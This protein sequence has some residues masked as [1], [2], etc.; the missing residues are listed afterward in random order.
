MKL[1][2]YPLD[3]LVHYPFSHY[4]KTIFTSPPSV[5]ATFLVASKASSVLLSERKGN[6]AHFHPNIAHFNGAPTPD[7]LDPNSEESTKF[8]VEGNYYRDV[9]KKFGLGRGGFGTLIFETPR[10]YDNMHGL[11]GADGTLGQ[12]LAVLKTDAIRDVISTW[13]AS[14]P[15]EWA[16]FS[17]K[18]EPISVHAS[19]KNLDGVFLVGIPEAQAN[20]HCLWAKE[21]GFVLTAAVPL[22]VAVGNWALRK[23]LAEV[24]Y[25]FLVVPGTQKYRGFF[26]NDGRVEHYFQAN[27][28]QYVAGDMQGTMDE[29]LLDNPEC[30]DAPLYIWPTEG[31][32]IP[33]M[34]DQFLRASG[35]RP[36]IVIDDKMIQSV[37]GEEFLIL[38]SIALCDWVATASIPGHKPLTGPPNAILIGE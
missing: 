29:A 8:K 1:L 25:Y 4:A 13:Q 28:E 37:Y 35:A 6:S 23:G 36:P 18:M 5:D 19:I 32:D 31:M 16:A 11:Q 14:E 33:K 9:N 38:P 21:T 24:P 10:M 3:F 30:A 17:R 15:Y 22:V 26:I 34:A 12:M 27:T 7:M 20:Y 2:P